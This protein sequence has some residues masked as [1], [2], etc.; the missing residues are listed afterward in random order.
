MS[1]IEAALQSCSV[2]LP[3]ELQPYIQEFYALYEQRYAPESAPALL[4]TRDGNAPSAGYGT[5]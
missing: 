2:L 4:T 3:S 5:S 1:Q